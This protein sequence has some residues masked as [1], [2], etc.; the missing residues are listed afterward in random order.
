MI[1][2]AK[3]AEDETENF[4]LSVEQLLN[5]TSGDA[6]QDEGQSISVASGSTIK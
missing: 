4:K 3:E 5:S 2:L 1:G 6:G